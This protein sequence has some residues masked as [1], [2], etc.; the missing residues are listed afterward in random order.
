[1]TKVLFLLSAVVMVV[2]A[3][4]SYQNHETFVKV[5]LERQATNEDIVKD[6]EEVRKTRKEVVL[7][8]DNMK[9]AGDEVAQETERLNQ[10]KIKLKNVTGEADRSTQ[11]ITEKQTRLKD[12]QDKLA[13][14]FKKL[15]PGTTVETLAE[16]VNQY[17]TTIANNTKVAE[18]AA[19]ATKAKQE[20]VKKFRAELESTVKRLDDRKGKF[21]LNSL[22]ARVVAVNSDWGFVVI[23]AGENKKITPETKLLV[24]RGNQTVGKLSIIAV[25]STKTVANIDAKSLR[26]GLSIAPGDRVILETLMQ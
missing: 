7:I 21:E 26:S 17:K 12:L 10:A 18:D 9:K 14:V 1:M 13:E 19:V 8:E 11:D 22:N 4:F 6:V 24:T 20:E 23:D 16:T 5:R 3:F 15:P 25:E 2:A